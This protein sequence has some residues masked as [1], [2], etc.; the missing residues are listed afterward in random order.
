MTYHL[1]GEIDKETF[2]KLLDFCRNN[3]VEEIV[4]D[5]SGGCFKESMKIIDFLNRCKL[6]VIAS[7]ISSCG[8]LIFYSLTEC[9]RRILPCATGMMHQGRYTI[10]MDS[11]ARPKYQDDKHYVNKRAR[12]EWNI[13]RSVLLSV[14]F[15]DLEK[16]EKDDD[17]FYFIDSEL[18][19]FL[20]YQIKNNHKWPTLIQPL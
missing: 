16:M 20:D 10:D 3:L 9:E 2:N 1:Q 18:Q 4:I 17:D 15:S 12:I 7:Q 19:S 13:M 11:L 8:F 5:T 14:G 6:K